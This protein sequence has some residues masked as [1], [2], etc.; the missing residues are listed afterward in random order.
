MR[1]LD[2]RG[3]SSG[4]DH[5]EPQQKNNKVGNRE[6]FVW[7]IQNEKATRQQGSLFLRENSS[8]GGLK[9]VKTFWRNL[10]SLKLGCQ[11]KF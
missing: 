3:L 6:R 8:N 5:F 7:P 9:T 2:S 11:G 10:M 1:Y 4:K